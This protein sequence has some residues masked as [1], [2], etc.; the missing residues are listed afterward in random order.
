[1]GA[2]PTQARAWHPAFRN[3]NHHVLTA[4]YPGHPLLTTTHSPLTINSP[5]S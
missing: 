5:C 2:M 4:P 1:M 3:R